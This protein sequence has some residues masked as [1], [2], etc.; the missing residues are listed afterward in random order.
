M[1]FIMRAES[2]KKIAFNLQISF[3]HFS[4]LKLL[5]WFP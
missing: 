1:N 5:C 3:F 4:L 2:L